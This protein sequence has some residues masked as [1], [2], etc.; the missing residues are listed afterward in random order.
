MR[1]NRRGFSLLGALVSV[2]V[3]GVVIYVSMTVFTNGVLQQKYI[4][5][6]YSVMDLHKAIYDQLTNAQ[7]CKSTFTAP[8]QVLKRD[9]IDNPPVE[10]FAS[11]TSIKSPDGLTN[12]YTKYV[13]AGD[14]V[15]ENNTVRIDNFTVKGYQDLG[16]DANG[17]YVATAMLEIV[18]KQNVRTVGSELFKAKQIRIKFTFKKVPA[19]DATNDKEVQT[20][21]AVG[22]SG[23]SFW[24]L[25]GAGDGIFYNG[26]MVGIGTATPIAPLHVFFNGTAQTARID[27]ANVDSTGFYINNSAPGG[28]GYIIA[29]SANANVNSGGKLL[30]SDA[31]AGGPVRMAIDSTGNVGIGTANPITK[32]AVDSTGGGPDLIAV[33]KPPASVAADII[34]SYNGSATL[35]DNASASFQYGVQPSTNN[36]VITNKPL[37]SMLWTNLVT[38]QPNGWVGIGTIAP[39]TALDL[40]AGSISGG[41]PGTHAGTTAPVCYDGVTGVMDACVSL[42]KFKKNIRPLDIGID[43]I[44][45]LQPVSYEMKSSGGKEIGFIAEDAVKVDQRFG[46]EST[47]KKVVGVRYPQMVAL[48]TK[49]IQQLYS[50]DD[51]LKRRIEELESETKALKGYICSKDPSA[52]VCPRK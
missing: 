10:E 44:L 39:R 25:T 42:R 32:L 3:L 1:S 45:R 11:I 18:Y 21:S 31:T 17:R 46:Q 19:P 43:E 33:V 52:P 26:G 27:G 35:W 4:E 9:D 38:V 50:S 23:D 36:W 47:D 7:A 22:G 6:R 2:T 14:P 13:S 5:Q 37:G 12:V 51:A 20:C 34:S 24:S 28:R 49:G 16:L 40:N 29:S 30:F 41:F 8:G 15:Y 48:L